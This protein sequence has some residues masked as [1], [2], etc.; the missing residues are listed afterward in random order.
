MPLPLWIVI[1]SA[2]VAIIAVGGS[3][4]LQRRSNITPAASDGRRVQAII[5]LWALGLLCAAALYVLARFGAPSSLIDVV[6]LFAGVPIVIAR[7]RALAQ[8]EGRDPLATVHAA[9]V[10]GFIALGV[11]ALLA[12]SAGTQ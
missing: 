6:L 12:L 4:Y 9:L 2:A 11:V 8:R 7:S 3:G 5:V 1:S 10:L